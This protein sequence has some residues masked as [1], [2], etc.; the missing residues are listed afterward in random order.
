MP[1]IAPG[2]AA[3]VIISAVAIVTLVGVS[4]SVSGPLLSLEM[5][6]W[7]TPSTL[8]GLTATLAGLGNL[9]FV[10][11]VPKLAR[12]VGVKRLVLGMLIAAAMLHVAFWL[13]PVLAI[14]AGLRFLLGASIGTLFVLSEF[15]I[16][17]A[18]DPRRRGM[19]MGAYATALAL[20]FSAGPALLALTGTSGALPYVAT[21]VLILAGALPLALIGG[22]A[23]EVHGH[24]K[25]AVPH[26]MRVAP[27][28]TLAA[29]V[30]GAVEIGAFTQLPIHGL[31]IGF[32]EIDAAMLVS[33]FAIGNV[34]L[35]LPIGW[36]AD[37]VDRRRLLLAI[38]CGATL[39]ALA[40]TRTGNSLPLTWAVLMGLGGLVGALYT[41][42]LT[43]LAARFT[44]ADLVSAN[45]AFVMLYSVG[46]MAGPPLLGAGIDFGGSLGLPL[47]VSGL[48]A[49]YALL[50]LMRILRNPT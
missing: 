38:A 34:V 8:A 48:L 1:E 19:I 27:S 50:V 22:N 18:A 31:R 28:A 36:L 26:F 46:Q 24:P 12:L 20:G 29:L 10:P 39:L 40:L 3:R 7:G 47:A 13:M 4:L 43:T 23:P 35:Q 6:R 2:G 37:R 42:G 16:S 21:A 9:L 5:E 15:W 14:W 33:A 25:G 17:A 11:F 32:R 41:V 49:G 44:D 45:A 30:V